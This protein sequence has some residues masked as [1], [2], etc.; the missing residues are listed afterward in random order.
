MSIENNEDIKDKAEETA[1]NAEQQ[2]EETAENA[3]QQAEEAAGAE[4]GADAAAAEKQAPEEGAQ[5]EAPGTSAE[6]QAEE[7]AEKEDPRDKEISDLKDRLMR[8]MAEFDNYR[9]R[10]DK[11][12]SQNYEIG[13]TDFIQ[14]ILPVVDNFERGL[15]AC[16]EEDKEGS[17]AKGIE[18]IYKQLE[19]VLEEEGVTPIEA[20]GK[21]FDPMLHNAVLQQPSEEYESGKVIQEYQKGY[22]YKDRVIRHSMVVVAE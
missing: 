4:A 2:A 10:T 22:M 20:L 8:Q 1:E 17:F 16:S 14:K 19:K 6:E 11:E 3:E 13:K 5:E 15:D 18:M 9:K 12:K 21:D 7:P